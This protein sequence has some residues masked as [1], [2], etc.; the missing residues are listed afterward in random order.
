MLKIMLLV[1]NSRSHIQANRMK[2]GCCN[3]SKIVQKGDQSF[4]PVDI[5]KAIVQ[6]LNDSYRSS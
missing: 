3:H 1:V 4:K 5:V 2:L 6:V